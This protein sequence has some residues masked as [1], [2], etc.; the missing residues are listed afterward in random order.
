MLS[1][2]QG[3]KNKFNAVKAF[4]FDS[5]LERRRFEYLTMAESAGKISDLHRQ[6]SVEL[7]PDIKYKTDFDY[8]EDGR[9]VWEDTKGVITDRFRLLCKIWRLHGP[10]PLRVVKISKNGW[11]IAKTI[12]PHNPIPKEDSSVVE[13]ANWV[14]IIFSWFK[15]HC[16]YR[17]NKT[18]CACD[19]NGRFD[20]TVVIQCKIKNCLPLEKLKLTE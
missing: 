17:I 14:K 15:K 5:Q 2:I 6:T 4:G 16:G 10:G 19:I 20:A 18:R 11:V 1:M 3:K 12:N 13:Y 7:E 8:I 9:R